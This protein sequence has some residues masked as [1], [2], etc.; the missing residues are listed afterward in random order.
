MLEEEQFLA[1][2]DVAMP[3]AWLSTWATAVCPHLKD[4]AAGLRAFVKLLSGW[5]RDYRRGK[6]VAP[7]TPG[8]AKAGA[9]E[10]GFA[11]SSTRLSKRKR[12][13]C[14]GSKAFCQPLRQELFDWFI[15]YVKTTRA[16]VNS[17]KLLSQAQIYRNE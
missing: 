2:Q 15:D 10:S 12:K 14:E 6:L 8:K 13:D 9:G 4:D 5:K 7:H 3:K 17:R 11:V 16:R 1:S